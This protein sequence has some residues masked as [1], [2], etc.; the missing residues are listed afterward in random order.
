MCSSSAYEG[1]PE[2]PPLRYSGERPKLSRTPVGHPFHETVPS[3]AAEV[4][5]G[6]E[7]VTAWG[8]EKGPSTGVEAGDG[9]GAALDSAESPSAPG[10]AAGGSKSG[11]A[12]TG[13]AA[14]ASAIAVTAGAAAGV[15]RK[16]VS[17]TAAACCGPAVA[18]SAASPTVDAAATAPAV[19]AAVKAVSKLLRV[20][21]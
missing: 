9:G 7:A 13:L 21:D 18:A 19:K 2:L 6:A 14:P 11:A 1:L 12:G 10:T 3:L 17:A 5:L 20:T 15:T 8:N 4:G 16:A